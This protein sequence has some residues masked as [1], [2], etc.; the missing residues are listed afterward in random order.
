MKRRV[1]QYYE[2]GERDG[3]SIDIPLYVRLAC[4]A[5]VKGVED[6]PGP[7]D[8]GD[9]GKRKRKSKPNGQGKDK[10]KKAGDSSPKAAKPKAAKRKAKAKPSA[11]KT[12][13]SRKGPA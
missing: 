2:R 13:E 8:T 5:V 6:Y 4:F 12:R 10:A 7:E 3:K 9:K 1:V 11:K